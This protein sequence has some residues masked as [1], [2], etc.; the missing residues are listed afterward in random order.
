[1]MRTLARIFFLTFALAAA[2]A[3]EAP[4]WTRATPSGGWILALAQAPSAPETL[5]AAAQTGRLFRSLDGGAS[6]QP[7]GTGTSLPQ[8]VTDLV[9]D[10]G[11]PHTLYAMNGS[12]QILRTRDAGRT[13]TPVGPEFQ[14]VSALALDAEHPGELFAATFEGIYRSPDGGDTWAVAAFA[15]TPVPTVAIDPGATATLFAVTGGGENPAVFWKSTDRG[16]TWA[17]TPLSVPAFT[18]GIPRILFDPAHPGTLYAVFSTT[19]DTTGPVFRSRDGGASWRELTRAN[20]IRDLAVSP[21]GDL[22][23]ATDYGVA[24]S[25]DLGATWVPRLPLTFRAPGIPEDSVT[26]ILASPTTPGELFAAGFTGVWHSGSGGA[27]WAPLNQGIFSQGVYSFAVAPDAA[28]TLVA[29]ASGRVFR[30]ADRG[31]VWQRLP[32]HTRDPGPPIWIEAFDPRDPET[33]Y[34]ID[35]DGQADFPLVSR[36]GG[37]TW[38]KPRFP[39]DCYLAGSICD[40]SLGRIAVDPHAPDSFYV[41]GSYFFHFQGSGYFLLRS[42]D[43]G[44]TWDRLAPLEGIA[45]LVFDPERRFALHALT[46]TGFFQSSNGGKTWRPAGLG[47]PRHSCAGRSLTIDPQEPRR[48]YAGTTEGVFLSTDGGATFRPMNRG[49]ETA[50]IASVQV[51]PESSGR[52]YAG[53]PGQGVF[54]WSAPGR[55]WLP[56]NQGLP[57]EHFT[58]QIALDP[59]HPTLLYATTADQGIFRL[60]LADTEP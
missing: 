22:F 29:I 47:L 42:D 20:G 17:E 28:S 46:C 60:D 7:R 1:M 38:T 34:G 27:R 54:R 50:Q 9:V 35:S 37:R 23:A 4:R 55:R 51:D 45:A 58:G 6:W 40:V 24:R 19:F 15:G 16:A 5:Y 11:D 41:S 49:L 18:R 53:V 2:A 14:T 43:G 10:P 8:G 36:D 52:L 59:H 57:V 30:S 56:L 44:S 39:Y 33:I 32:R 25:T 31:A 3:A 12:P 21:R 26:R 13:W 48:L